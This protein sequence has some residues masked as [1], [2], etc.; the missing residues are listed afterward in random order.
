MQGQGIGYTAAVVWPQC[1]GTKQI[2]PKDVPEGLI[3][4]S[5]GLPSEFKIENAIFS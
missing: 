1:P 3:V 4:F 5:V 2:R